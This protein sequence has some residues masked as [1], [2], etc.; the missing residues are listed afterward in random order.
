MREELAVGDVEVDARATATTPPPNS[1][2]TPRSQI[3]GHDGTLTR[4]A[5][6]DPARSDPDGSS[7]AAGSTE[8]ATAW[9]D[10]DD[11]IRARRPERDW[12]SPSGT[13]HAPG[14]GREAC[15]CAVRARTRRGKGAL[16]RGPQLGQRHAR[17]GPGRR[18]RARARSV[19]DPIRACGK[20]RAAHMSVNRTSSRARHRDDRPAGR[21]AEQRDERVTP[22]GAATTRAP[23]PSRRQDSTSAWARPPSERS[24]AASTSPSRDGVDQ[25]SAS[26]LLGGQVDR[27]AAG[28]RGG[29]ARRAPTPSRTAPRGSRRAGTMLCPRRAKPVGVRR[30]DVVDHAE[31]ADDR[32]RQDRGRRR[33]GCRG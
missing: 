9:L 32:R 8:A 1:L 11:G 2:R 26:C 19:G 30:R 29:R 10:L 33:S 25:E 27:A 5:C 23:T 12:I 13:G 18:D 7:C 14:G 31:H 3:G 24:W 28:R 17:T 4:R 6:V 21:L 20:P 22:S 16:V 15:G